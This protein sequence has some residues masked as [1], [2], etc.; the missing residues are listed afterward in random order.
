MAA[1]GLAVLR[2]T[3][4]AVL[5]AHGSHQLFGVLNGPGVGPGGLSATSAYFAG[6]G[7][8]HPLPL[9]VLV[10]V[11]QFSGGLLIAIGFLTRWASLALV[12]TL[13]FLAWK[14][15]W[16]WGFFMNW[17][18]DPARGHGIEYAVI[19]AGGLLCLALTGAGD[20]SIDGRRNRRAAL[21]ASGRARLRTRD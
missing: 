20:L 19:L 16:R 4:A 14:D 11:L 21:R 18:L 12:G 7:L 5:L 9:A 17:A 13:G 10:G 8:T 2:L 3:L 6:I 1:L 15:A